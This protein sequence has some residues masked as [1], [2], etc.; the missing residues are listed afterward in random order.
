MVVGLLGCSKKSSAVSPIQEDVEVVT[1]HDRDGDGKPDLEKHRYPG[2]ADRDWE[3][4]DDDH[5]GR[6]EKKVVFGVRVIESTIDLAVP[7]GV[8]LETKP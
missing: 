6:F 5:N 7:V 8:K 4:R 1:Y 2:W 3:L